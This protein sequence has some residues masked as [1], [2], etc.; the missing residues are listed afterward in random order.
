MTTAITTAAL[1]VIIAAEAAVET[2]VGA[3]IDT[4]AL[5]AGARTTAGTTEARGDAADRGSA[6]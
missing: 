6:V 2:I 5:L 4:I 1:A 3:A